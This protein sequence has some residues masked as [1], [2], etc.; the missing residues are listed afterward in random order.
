MLIVGQSKRSA[1]GEKS[2]DKAQNPRPRRRG[3]Q[4]DGGDREPAGDDEDRRKEDDERYEHEPFDDP[5]EHR[6]IEE[7]R[8]QGSLPPTPERYAQAREQWY[9]LPGAVVRPSM[10]PP[11]APAQ[12]ATAEP[13]GEGT[14]Q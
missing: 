14:S 11:V 5:T 6:A 7:R 12:S 3:G 4:R 8:F 9:E 10:D 1:G 13:V 2:M